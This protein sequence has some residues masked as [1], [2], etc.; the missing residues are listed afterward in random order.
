MVIAPGPVRRYSVPES[1]VRG[2]VPGPSIETRESEDTMRCL[3][4]ALCLGLVLGLAGIAGADEKAD[5]TAKTFKGTI[6]CAKCDLGESKKCE[7][8]IKTKVGDKDVVYYFDADS[9]KKHHSKICNE[10]KEG[11]VTGTV[12]KDGDKWVI[13]ATKVEFK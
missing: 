1:A 8:V 3:Y 2:V 6:T 13:K 12:K 7:T 9:H 11:S 4:A 10:A 5:T